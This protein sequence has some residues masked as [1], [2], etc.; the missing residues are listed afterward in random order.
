MGEGHGVRWLDKRKGGKV[1]IGSARAL[2]PPLLVVDP[3]SL[4]PPS[5]R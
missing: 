5:Q 1:S 2:S 3:P 4:I